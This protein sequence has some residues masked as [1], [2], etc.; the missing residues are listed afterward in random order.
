MRSRL[1]VKMFGFRQRVH[2]S[3]KARPVSIHSGFII[4]EQAV[5]LDPFENIFRTT[6]RTE[7]KRKR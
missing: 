5:E 2:R 6:H 4:L 3:G 7:V 1:H